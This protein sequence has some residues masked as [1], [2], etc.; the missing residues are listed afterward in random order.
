MEEIQFDVCGQNIA[1]NYSVILTDPTFE[2]RL[3]AFDPN[4][5]LKFHKGL[6]RWMVLERLHDNSGLKPLIIAEDERGN[7]KPLGEWVFNKLFVFACK[8][9]EKIRRGVT[10]WFKDIIYEADKQREKIE[11][12]VSDDHQAQ[13]REDVMQWRKVSKELKNEPV[14]DATAGYQKL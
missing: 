8:H 5:V 2:A 4:L 1:E 6:R 7:P 12:N 10:N 13:L 9:E 11:E 3:K 14:S